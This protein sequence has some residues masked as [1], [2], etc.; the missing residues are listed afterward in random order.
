MST[1]FDRF[2]DEIDQIGDRVRDAVESSKL[3]LDR[4][5]YVG[6][7]SKAAYKLGMLIYKRER[8]TI[9]EQGQV[10][11]LITEL[12]EISGKIAEIDRKLEGLCDD[13]A[14]DE[15]KVE[16]QPAPPTTPGDAE[17]SGG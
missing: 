16:E 12:D 14:E 5:K 7:R 15:V 11:A 13:D 3:H 1:I 4:S 10:D 8:G 2:R 17:V 9:V 6:L